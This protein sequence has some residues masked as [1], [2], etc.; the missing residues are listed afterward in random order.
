MLL[1]LFGENSYER[2]Q[3]LNQRLADFS[4]SIERLDAENL[5]PADLADLFFSTNLF[6]SSRLIVV[7][8]AADNKPLWTELANWLTKADHETNLI[9]VEDKLDKRSKTYK[10]FQKLAGVHE[11]LAYGAK[12]TARLTS[13]LS[14]RAQAMDVDLTSQLARQLIDR[15]GLDQWRLASALEQL[16]VFPSLSSKLI[17]EIVP[18]SIEENVF[19]L[20]EL[21]LKGDRARLQ[22]VIA[23]LS[24]SEEPYKVF[25][26]LSAQLIQLAA[27]TLSDGP[28]GQ[29]AKDIGAHPFVLSK[30]DR[31][32]KQLSKADLAR[33]IAIFDQADADLKSSATPPWLI[34]ERCLLKL[35]N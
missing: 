10:Q 3:A 5:K 24:L 33:V 25:G 4:G 9:F 27:L 16:A 1:L 14:Q 20:F 15:V 7:R 35:A 2:S 6:A 34:I 31:F 12:D 28:A 18:L 17:D 30:L 29:V 32:A 19:E 26:L 11:Y 22:Q 23:S 13:W 21:A 8:A